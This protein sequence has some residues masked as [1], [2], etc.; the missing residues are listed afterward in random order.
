VV[1]QE[2]QQILLHVMELLMELVGD[3]VGTVV[4]IHLAHQQTEQT[5]QILVVVVQVAIVK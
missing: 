3:L 5:L 1:V 4:D 2:A